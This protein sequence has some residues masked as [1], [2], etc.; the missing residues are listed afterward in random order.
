MIL[1]LILLVSIY[2]N[3]LVV[4]DLNS[5]WNMKIVNGP[6]QASQ[7]INKDYQCSLPTVIHLELLKAGD[8]PDPFLKDYYPTVK[9]VSD[10]T[11]KFST[12]FTIEDTIFDW[13]HH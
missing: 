2:G 1:L 12:N 8:I 11:V 9:W 3:N 13:D 6:T 10:C 7:Y 4:K 5:N